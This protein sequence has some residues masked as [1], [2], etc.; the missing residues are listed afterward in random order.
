[1]AE[2]DNR[3]LQHRDHVAASVK[4]PLVLLLDNVRDA[5]NVG[6]IFR[7]A[8]ALGVERL[9]LCGETASPPDRRLTRSARSTHQVVAYQQREESLRAASELRAQGYQLFALELS[10]ASVDLKSVDFRMHNRI[11]L[12]LGGERNGLSDALLEIVDQTVHIPMLGQNSSMNV[13][14]ACAIALYEIT[15]HL[16]SVTNGD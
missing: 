5:A 10:R 15:R 6:G 14:S 11:C 13:T 16:E 4:H 8:D 1:M 12:L 3:Q 2:I 9:L 7:L